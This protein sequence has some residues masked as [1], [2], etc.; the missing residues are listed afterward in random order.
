MKEN[1][2]KLRE[3]ETDKNANEKKNCQNFLL[4]LLYKRSLLPSV[5]N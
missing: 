1:K 5:K 4:V 2:K 3:R